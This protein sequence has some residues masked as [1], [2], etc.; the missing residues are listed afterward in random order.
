MP[1]RWQKRSSPRL[2]TAGALLLLGGAVGVVDQ[3]VWRSDP[4]LGSSPAVLPLLGAL[5]VAGA[6]C[7]A[8]GRR[9]R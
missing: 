9:W 4:V 3:F 8:L 5:L 7:F 1:T 6:A 2:R